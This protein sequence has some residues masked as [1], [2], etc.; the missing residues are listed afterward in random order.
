[1]KSII[2]S[3]TSAT[4]WVLSHVVIHVTFEKNI[5]SHYCTLSIN[6]F[7]RLWWLWNKDSSSFSLHVCRGTRPAFM[8]SSVEDFQASSLKV[9][10]KARADNG[11]SLITGYR[12]IIKGDTE[13]DSVK[14]ADPGTT[15]HTF[16]GLERD[17]NY[18]MKMFARNAEFEYIK[19]IYTFFLKD[20]EI[21]DIKLSCCKRICQNS[22]RIFRCERNKKQVIL[23]L[24]LLA[25]LL[26]MQHFIHQ[27]AFRSINVSIWASTYL[28]LP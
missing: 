16:G 14:I 23:E 24:K 27:L 5:L 4:H 15:S 9:R 10:W 1:M 7:L 3:C 20:M 11:G 21:K 25:K 2:R 19:L 22:C 28:P 26:I 13:R 17:T 12:M 8:A 6:Y 18:A